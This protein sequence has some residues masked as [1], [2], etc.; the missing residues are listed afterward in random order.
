MRTNLV[1]RFIAYFSFKNITEVTHQGHVSKLIAK[2]QF[3]PLCLKCFLLQF[4]IVKLL[5]SQY[6]QLNF[7]CKWNCQFILCDFIEK[8][9]LCF[10]LCFWMYQEESITQLHLC[11]TVILCKLVFIELIECCSQ[12]LL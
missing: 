10:I 8:V 9:L 4:N 11:I 5:L 7:P 2:D 12:A 6:T 1:Q 3:F